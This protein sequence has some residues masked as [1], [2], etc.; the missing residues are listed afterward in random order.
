MNWLIVAAIMV[1][2]IKIMNSNTHGL[3]S[4][5]TYTLSF[6]DIFLL[7]ALHYGSGALAENILLFSYWKLFLGLKFLG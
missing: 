2:L 1:I 4:E 7:Q 3:I 5:T 6:L